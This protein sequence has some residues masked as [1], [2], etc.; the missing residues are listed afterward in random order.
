MDGNI[1]KSGL[2]RSFLLAPADNPELL[3]KQATSAA[4]AVTL[5][6]EDAVLPERKD[7]ARKIA[8]EALRTLDY[9]GKERFIRMNGLETDFWLDDLEYFC[10]ESPPTGFTVAKVRSA[11]D[12]RV[13]SR[14]LD[15]LEH[16]YKLAEGSIYISCM[17]E[18]A[19]AMRDVYRIAAASP[20]MANIHFG[21]E[22]FTHSIDAIRTPEQYEVFYAM[23]RIVSAARAAGIEPINVMYTAVNDE[24]GLRRSSIL[25]RQFGFTGRSCPTPRHIPVIHEI[26]SPTPEEVAYA[27]KIVDGYTGSATEISGVYVIDGKMIDGPMIKKAFRVLERAKK[28]S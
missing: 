4:D 19:E 24:A 9:G 26:F 1:R 6:I 28:S 8:S 27:Q 20:R 25:A 12:I 13:V 17:I 5:C 10:R 22:D 7:E 15:H 14:V 16:R 11:E 21:A 2:R 18:T 3:K 23:S